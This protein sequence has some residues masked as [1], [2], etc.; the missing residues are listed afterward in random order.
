VRLLA[1]SW[2]LVATR[3]ELTKPRIVL[4][5]M[6]TASVGY[7]IGVEGGPSLLALL[8]VLIGT[9][10][11]AAGAGALNQVVERDV[12]GL[13]RRTAGRPLPSGRMTSAEAAA[14]ALAAS[15]GG[16][17][18]LALLVNGATAAMA[19]LTV[20]SY[21]LVYTPLKRRTTLA[22]LVG[23]VPG[24]LPIV[25]G[26]TAA[27]GTVGAEAWVLFWIVFLW[28]LPHFLALAW[29][30]REDYARAGLK[31]L[32][33]GDLDGRVTFRQAVLYA[34]ALIPISLVPAAL[35]MAGGLYFVGAAVLSGWFAWA[36]AR[37]GRERSPA[38][39]RR[40]FL[41]SLVYLPGIL[42]LMV[43]SRPS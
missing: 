40:L 8:H 9:G 37:A 29:M 12:D 10:L 42:V 4:M 23:A 36:T 32:C 33:V 19:G 24:A 16:V 30:C 26:W 13:M 3:L 18:Y 2:E 1:A 14:I 22:T 11:V 27:R 38:T 31:M 21:V 20:A 7:L 5:V 39:A 28:Q 34:A 43:S 25:G 15:A 41:A 35:G 17:L 6:L